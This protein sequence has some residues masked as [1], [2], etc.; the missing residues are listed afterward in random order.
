MPVSTAMIG[1]G[2][3]Y[4]LPTGFCSPNVAALIDALKAP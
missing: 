2:S 1:D 4:N 3:A